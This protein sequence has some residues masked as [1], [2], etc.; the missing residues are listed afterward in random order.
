MKASYIIVHGRA[1]VIL[2]DQVNAFVTGLK[3]YTDGVSQVQAGSVTLHTGTTQLSTGA[4]DLSTG[5]ATLSTGASDL[6]TGA[7]TL[8]EG[9]G[10]LKTG[11]HSAV[12]KAS[13]KALPYLTGDIRKVLDAFNHTKDAVAGEHGYDLLSDSMTAETVYIIR[14][15]M[16]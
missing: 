6:S 13:D 5:A 3:T 1:A 8:A 2:P 7:S 9:A 16:K 10:Q 11:M 15:D 14:T 4:S 12:A